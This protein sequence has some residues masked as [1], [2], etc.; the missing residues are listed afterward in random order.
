MEGEQ[1]HSW[2]LVIKFIT[3]LGTLGLLIFGIYQ[4]NLNNERAFRKEI[5]LLQN[6]AFTKLVD[7][8]SILANMDKDS[9][10]TKEFFQHYINFQRVH[11]GKLKFVNDD[12]LN[13]LSTVFEEKLD[14]YRIRNNP[15]VTQSDLKECV[16]KLAKRC[17]T[18]YQTTW[19]VKL[20]HI[21]NK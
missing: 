1:Y 12:S 14:Q 4:Y 10:D 2:D 13:Y 7:E 19:D 9:V 20:S 6:D 8:A 16:E 18:L 11:Y 3:G 15:S 21:N 5:Y 17:V